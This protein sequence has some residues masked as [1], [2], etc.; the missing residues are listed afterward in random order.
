MKERSFTFFILASSRIESYTILM[1]TNH[2]ESRPIIGLTTYRKMVDKNNPYPYMALM[3]TY[4][5]AVTAAGG[6]PLL[7]PL[8]LD[9]DALRVLLS[10]VDGLVLTGGG[11][12]AGEHYRSE[13]EDF[14]FNVDADRDR[15]EFFLAREAMAQDK[16][17]LAICRGHQVLNVALGGTLYEDVKAW[18]PGAMKHD[19]FE[20][21]PRE[22]K[23]HT[24]AIEPGS[25]LAEALG[26]RETQVNSLHHQGIRDLAPGLAAVAHAPDG[27]IESVEGVDHPFALGVQWHPENLVHDDPMMLSLVRGLV[28]A[29]S[30]N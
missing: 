23:A 27:L 20:I 4:V 17:M 24:V 28:E 22:H 18:M 3:A 8:G 25:K 11:D 6:I 5:E 19:Y 21:F 7:I 9:E 15:V 29:A 12:I 1:T 16:P 30:A 10:Q 13:H 26:R 2:T 14:I